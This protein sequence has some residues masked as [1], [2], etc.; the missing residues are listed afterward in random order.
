MAAAVVNGD[1]AKV[2]CDARAGVT[3][4]VTLKSGD[5]AWP[6]ATAAAVGV[7]VVVACC[8]CVM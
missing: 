7:A 4:F 3:V 2:D 1:D 6:D 5:G 8:V